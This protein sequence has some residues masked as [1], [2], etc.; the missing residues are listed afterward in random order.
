MKSTPRATPGNRK[1]TK[2]LRKR[3]PFELLSQKFRLD[4]RDYVHQIQ[5][6]A[7][8]RGGCVFQVTL[9]PVQLTKSP[10]FPLSS[11]FPQLCKA[12]VCDLV[13]VF[14]CFV[15]PLA[16]WGRRWEGTAPAQ[17][18]V[19]Q[20]QQN[21]TKHIKQNEARTNQTN[22]ATLPQTSLVIPPIMRNSSDLGNTRVILATPL[23]ILAPPVGNYSGHHFRYVGNR[24]WV[25]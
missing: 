5:V 17:R 15:F 8:Q 1:R 7:L 12:D 25:T 4:C 23:A 16:V 9:E 10:L 22:L 11:L 20:K 2:S 14:I 21:T 19:T 13:L 3:L 18:S 24:G 6:L